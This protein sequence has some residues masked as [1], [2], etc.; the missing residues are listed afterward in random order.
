M[1]TKHLNLENSPKHPKT[2]YT[3]QPG[4]SVGVGMHCDTLFLDAFLDA[5]V[6]IPISEHVGTP[7]YFAMQILWW[8]SALLKPWKTAPKRSS[9]DAPQREHPRRIQTFGLRWT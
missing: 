2:S 5:S 7:A 8:Y 1:S 6:F 9:G 4:G 3:L